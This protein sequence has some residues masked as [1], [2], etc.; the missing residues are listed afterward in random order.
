MSL[1]DGG[2]ERQSRA[3]KKAAPPESDDTRAKNTALFRYPPKNIARDRMSQ[4][5]CHLCRCYPAGGSRPH[6]GKL[7]QKIS[8]YKGS[9]TR[10]STGVNNF[11]LL[12]QIYFSL[13]L[14]K[15]PRRFRSEGISFAFPPYF[16]DRRRPTPS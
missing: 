10:F 8:L 7:Y 14:Q 6:L 11:F 4:A 2:M 5:S 9:V 13:Q 1:A 16:P 15:I 3:T 12:R